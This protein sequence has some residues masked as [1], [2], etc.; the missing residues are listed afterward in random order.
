MFR[1][2]APTDGEPV[3][4]FVVRLRQQARHCNFGETLDDNLRD[5]TIEKLP[6]RKRERRKLRVIK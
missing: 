4:K 2:L 3:D 5:Q 6:D 1:Q